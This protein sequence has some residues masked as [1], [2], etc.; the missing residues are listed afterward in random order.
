MSLV[1]YPNYI[2]G[3]AL[4]NETGETFEV[5]NPATG[6]VSYLVEVA[7]EKIQQ[8]AIKSAKEGFNTWSKM[9]AMERS[10]IL[11]KA[12]ALL[13]ERNDELAA[14]EVTDTGKPWQEASV[15]D[16]VTGADSIEFFAGLA[17]SIEGNQQTV[18]DDF[19]Y[20]RRE[21]LGICAGIGAW[22]YP[23]QIA[24]WK[25]APA[26]ACGNVMIFKPSE[27]TPLG[28]LKLAE[29]FTQAGVPDGV[30]NVI[31]GDGRVGA[32]LTNNEEIAK[33]SFTGEVGT[34]KK[35]M[36]A[37]ASSLKQ[38][39]MEL[40]GKSPLIIFNDADIDNAV[41]AAMLGNFYTQGEICTNGTRVFVQQDI[42]PI[43]VEKLL[44]R[45]RD[46]IVC[47]DPMDPATNF[48]ALISKDHQDNV[49]SYIE[50]GKQEGA[51]LLAGGHALTPDNSPNGYFVAPTIFGQCSDEMT[52]S[53][54]E[55]FGPVM[56]L[57]PFSDENEVIR[58]AN[59][60][61]LGLAAGVFTQDI[62]RAHRVIHQ[63]QAGI[64]WINAYGASPAEMP[65]GGYK[66]SGIGRENGSETLKAYTQI[67][68]VYVGM[69]PLESPF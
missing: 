61:R 51:E 36:A 28:A 65:V 52:L 37:A 9:T 7:D 55:V 63:M 29:I 48:G 30:F 13:R 46:N 12:V 64:C 1:I 14:I 44:Q 32:W 50:I 21:P 38:V 26:L 56:S 49:L 43:F 57:L 45:T 31:Q 39:T 66:M 6:K 27:E 67:K 10:R 62:T 42:Y 18:G 24:C 25:A 5:T 15:V 41:S 8:A 20:T 59:G 34:G 53:K 47:G 33:I 35:V 23:L 2:H 54:E 16:V 60:T 22:N 68:A 3:Q 40:G 4:N 17:P 11:L 19:Y 69:Q 58:R